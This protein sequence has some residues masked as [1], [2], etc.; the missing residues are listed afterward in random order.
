[1]TP[2]RKVVAIIP[3]RSGSKRIPGKNIKEFEGI[4]MIS[5]AIQILLEAEL[6]DEVV[7]ST[8]S[9]D[10]IST[11]SAAG[12]TS[13]VTRPK[14]L[15]DDHTATKPVIQHA[16]SELTLSDDDAVCCVYPCNPFLNPE[17][18]RKSLEL[19]VENKE[20]FCLPV[21]EY[22]HPVQRAFTLDQRSVITKRER[23]FELSRTQDLEAC[24]HDAGSF[25]WGIKSLWMSELEL[26]SQSLGLPVTRTEGLDI[27]TPDDWSFAEL[28]YRARELGDLQ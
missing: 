28:L 25:Y 7:V 3:A 11:S 15:A 27:D 24:Y 6:F 9:P 8:D 22:P 4:P 21:I 5:R 12:A 13:C 19:L 2:Q 1:M 17:T 14:E 26:H 10:I 20:Y 18:L 16:L 23:H